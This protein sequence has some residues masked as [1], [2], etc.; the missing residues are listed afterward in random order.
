MFLQ[1]Q[2]PEFFNVSRWP[3]VQRLGSG[4][5]YLRGRD[6]SGVLALGELPPSVE[7]IDLNGNS[8]LDVKVSG[9]MVKVLR[10][11]NCNMRTFDFPALR[12]SAVESLFLDLN[13]MQSGDLAV[14]NGTAVEALDLA[15]TSSSKEDT[16]W[17]RLARMRAQG[18]IRLDEV[19][20]DCCEG[21]MKW[22]NDSQSFHV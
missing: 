22:D 15:H 4:G 8:R 21:S 11:G 6:L 18:E 20:F 2:M 19:I 16:D 12:G 5:L 10:L 3:G 13:P 1:L 17:S 14:L 7:N 9:V